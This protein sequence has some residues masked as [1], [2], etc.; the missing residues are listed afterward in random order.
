MAP[1]VLGAAAD[2]IRSDSGA[3]GVWLGCWLTGD[4]RTGRINP[5]EKAL[6][7]SGS[8]HRTLSAQGMQASNRRVLLLRRRNTITNVAPK[9]RGRPRETTAQVPA[10]PAPRHQS[11]PQA[12]SSVP[13]RP[14]HPEVRGQAPGSE[15]TPATWLAVISTAQRKG[16]CPHT[17]AILRG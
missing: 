9:G 14:P 12:S 8:D 11:S 16:A 7:A 2:A 15:G 1:E 13:A 5:E 3:A 17:C 6:G 10:L 4:S